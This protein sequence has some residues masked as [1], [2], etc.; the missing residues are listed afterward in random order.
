MN[1]NVGKHN[2]AIPLPVLFSCGVKG[3]GQVFVFC[4]FEFYFWP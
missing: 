1:M 4:G 2:E 3:G